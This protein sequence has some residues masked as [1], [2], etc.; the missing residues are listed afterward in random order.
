MVTGSSLH[1]PTFM[2][3]LNEL[4]LYKKDSSNIKED[5][6]KVFNVKVSEVMNYV[7]LSFSEE[8]S[9][10]EIVRTFAEHHRVNPVPVI[11]EN[12]KVVGIIS[13]SDILQFLRPGRSHIYNK[14]DIDKNILDLLNQHEDRFTLTGKYRT[15]LWLI[16]G[17]LLAAVGFA[18]AWFWI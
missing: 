11:D 7:P 15:K 5:F 1:I 2:K 14:R 18:I 3:F 16:A 9:I 12:Q 4:E 17:I 8:T 6:N 13:R 10:E